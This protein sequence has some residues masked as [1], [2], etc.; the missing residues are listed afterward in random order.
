MPWIPKFLY[1]RM[2]TE[3]VGDVEPVFVSL[4]GAHREGSDAGLDLKAIDIMTD[5]SASAAPLIDGENPFLT[6]V[7]RAPKAWL[8]PPICLLSDGITRSAPWVSG[9]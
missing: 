8:L 1:E 9:S 3:D 2:S 4:S 7:H 5:I 6:P